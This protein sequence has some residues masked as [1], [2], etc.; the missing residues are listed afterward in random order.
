MREKS[1]NR[2]T[3][4]TTIEATLNLDGIGKTDIDTKIPFFDHM[5]QQI[6][7]HGRMDL[8]I[9][10]D[11]DVEVDDHHSIEDVGLVLGKMFRECIGDKSGLERFAHSYVTMDETLTRCVVDLC[12]RPFFS[13]NVKTSLEKVG[14][15]EIEMFPEFFKSFV[16]EAK[17]NCHIDCIRGSNNH[18]IIESCFKSFALAIRK[19]VFKDPNFNELP[20][21]KGSLS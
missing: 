5:L 18:H 8:K 19:S 3:N 12:D 21:S 7:V 15:I 10:C 17:I 6:A 1:F 14:N 16:N 4:E 20:S 11:G 9:K 2:T 13:W